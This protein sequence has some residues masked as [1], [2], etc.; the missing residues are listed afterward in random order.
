MKRCLNISL[1]YFATMSIEEEPTREF[2]LPD[3][4][5]PKDIFWCEHEIRKGEEG[6]CVVW[7]ASPV[8][9][10]K[11]PRPWHII[12]A[13]Q[14]RE[15]S[16]VWDLHLLRLQLAQKETRGNCLWVF[17]TCEFYEGTAKFSR[18]YIP[19]YLT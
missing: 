1:R 15:G 17:S 4:D 8:F 10:N 14:A 16:D 7:N 11:D 13:I 9:L 18:K 12:S 5:T 6:N 2:I 3:K 19:T